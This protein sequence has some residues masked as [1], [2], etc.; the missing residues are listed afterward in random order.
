MRTRTCCHLCSF[1][2]VSSLAIS[3]ARPLSLSLHLTL[4]LV[5]SLS[6][7]LSHARYVAL[8]LNL[9]FWLSR[10]CALPPST[11]T[12]TSLHILLICVRNRQAMEEELELHKPT[13]VMCAAGLTG[14]PNVDWCETN[15]VLHM[16]YC[17]AIC[18]NM[19]QLLSRT[20]HSPLRALHS[21][22][23]SSLFLSQAPSLCVFRKLVST[24]TAKNHALALIT[25]TL[26]VFS[27]LSFFL[28]LPPAVCVRVASDVCVSVR[29]YSN[30][31]STCGLT[32]LFIHGLTRA[33]THTHTQTHK[34]AQTHTQPH[35]HTHTPHTNTHTH[36][37][38]HTYRNTNA[39]PPSH[40]HT[41]P[42]TLT[43]AVTIQKGCS[44]KLH[45]QA[46]ALSHRD[47]LTHANRDTHKHTHRQ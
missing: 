25:H 18:F 13:R 17:V 27:S 22:L 20:L 10:A 26:S 45:C 3:L 32:S 35:T 46:R 29:E 7:S 41:R 11:H 40:T 38:T 4:F 33:Y 2:L 37:H 42:H 44:G 31:P 5:L 21:P 23:P 15:Q 1:Y 39:T 43:K 47:T 6:F 30:D 36:T 16:V 12:H 24:R 34:H 19:L 8:S 28:V 9:C 14:R